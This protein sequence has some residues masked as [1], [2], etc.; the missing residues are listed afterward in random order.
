M[1]SSARDRQPQCPLL[2]QSRHGLVHRKCLLLTQSGLSQTR[3]RCYA[4]A[5]LYVVPGAAMRRREFIGLIGG[6]AATWPF[7]VR[8][9]QGERMR[10][11]GDVASPS[12]R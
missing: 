5:L 4:L 8:A 10:R 12:R 11:I 2:A 6:V 3:S 7:A 1:A 9:Q